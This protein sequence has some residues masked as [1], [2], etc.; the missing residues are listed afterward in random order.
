MAL[1]GID[2]WVIIVKDLEETVAFYRKLGLE[3]YWQDKAG[4]ESRRP[5]FPV[6]KQLIKFYAAD[7]YEIESPLG[8]PNYGT[9][10]MDFCLEW[11]GTVQELQDFLKEAGIPIRS[12]PK[13]RG[14]QSKGKGT[15]IYVR[16]PDGNLLEMM[17]YKG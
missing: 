2:H 9:G 12:G 15:S 4:G 3:E 13:G 8:A 6:G 1:S 5:I 10:N 11:D 17:S 16:D 7:R 14:G